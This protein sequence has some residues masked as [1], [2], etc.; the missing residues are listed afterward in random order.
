MESE[1]PMEFILDDAIRI[2][3][4]TPETL[5]ALLAALP[6]QWARCDEG[7]DTWSPFDVL[8]HL[9]HGEKTDWVPR[10]LS[11]LEYGESQV[12]EPFDRFAQF[13]D[14][15]GKSL[16]TL[17]DEFTA[18]RIK[19]VETI[20]ALHLTDDELERT[21]LHPDFGRVTLAQLLATWAVHDLGHIVQISRTMARQYDA[22]VGPWKKYLRVLS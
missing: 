1:G 3:R 19:N 5:R 7:P 6:D 4:R 16:G 15:R 9:I 12:F 13:G 11:I 18:L 10:A 20:E 14:S 17:L 22:Q 2:L 8:G 21:G